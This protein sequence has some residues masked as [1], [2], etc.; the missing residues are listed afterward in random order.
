MSFE[1]NLDQ[2]VGDVAGGLIREAAMLKARC[3]YLEATNA[4]LQDQ[5]VQLKQRLNDAGLST[6]K[7]SYID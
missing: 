4:G 6:E 2:Y 5:I 7:E 3:A 1:K